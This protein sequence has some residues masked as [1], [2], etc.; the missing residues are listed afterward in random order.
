VTY[1]ILQRTVR[2]GH[3][4]VAAFL[5]FASLSLTVSS[6]ADSAKSVLVQYGMRFELPAIEA[7]QRG[8]DAALQK[9][10]I[11]KRLLP[12]NGTIGFREPSLWQEYRALVVGAAIFAI[13][14]TVLILALLRSLARL[15]RTRRELND[16]LRFERLISGLSARF[17]NIPQEKVDSEVERGLDEVVKSM[18]LD[19]CALFELLG[20]SG[21]LRIT[22]KSRALDAGVSPFPSSEQRLPWFFGQISSGKAVILQAAAKDL[23]AAAVE[24]RAFYREFGI[25]SA[26]AFPFFQTGAATRGILYATANQDE[27]WSEEIIPDLRSIGQ[28]LASAL[29]RKDAEESLR[30]NEATISLAAQSADLGLWSRDIQTGRIWATKR[31]RTMY[32]F[33]ADGEVTFSRFLESLHPDDRLTTEKAIAAAV[34]DRCDYNIIHRIVQT[35][36]T[37]R[38]IA[39]RGRA[40]YSAAGQALKMMGASFDITERRQRALETEGNRQELAHLGRVALMVEMATSLAHELNQPLTAIVTNAGA[41][42]RFLDQGNVDIQELHELL[43]DIASDGERAGKII[44]GIREMVR[45]GDAARE[46]VDVNQVV[47]DVVRLTNSD[48]VRN[49]CAIVTELAPQPAWVEADAVQLQQ[50]FLNLVLNAFDAMQETSAHLRRVVLSTNSTVDGLIHAS[51]RDFGIGLSKKVYQ[52]AFAHFFSTKKDGLGMG[53][54]IARSIVESFGGSLDAANAPD[55]GAVFYFNL[56]AYCDR[57][58]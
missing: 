3:F 40:I 31:T 20:G 34:A 14:E 38:W 11:A 4:V 57:S 24:E 47:K 27:K 54:A 51:V 26:L 9:W 41:G 1:G 58:K 37:V 33:S 23:P 22:H 2:C 7:V 12:S 15:H 49:S 56:P 28:I 36:G 46:I 8:L 16:R 44:R 18:K 10:R 17:L 48:A 53:L 6:V 25:K 52:R 19:R 39:A 50:V 35:D 5:V 55:G 45:K 42:Q 32:G 29:A 21:N 13:V 30:E 43:L